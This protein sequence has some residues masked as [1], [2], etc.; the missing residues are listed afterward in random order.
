MDEDDEEDED[1][2]E[3]EDEVEAM[4]QMGALE[5]VEG[6]GSGGGAAAA[7]PAMAVDEADLPPINDESL[8]HVKQ[9]N[10]SDDEDEP[11]SPEFHQVRA[12]VR[13]C[14]CAR[15]QRAREGWIDVCVG[16]TSTLYA[17]SFICGGLCVFLIVDEMD[18]CRCV[19]R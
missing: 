11:V 2:D 9:L 3:D 12:C 14:L 1:E 10:L 7:I 5:G 8:A 18:G 6:A 13:A 19:R 16:H 15:E 17:S 4:E